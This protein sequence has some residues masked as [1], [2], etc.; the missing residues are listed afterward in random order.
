[1]RLIGYSLGIP[2]QGEPNAESC[3]SLQ[4][5][6]GVVMYAPNRLVWWHLLSQHPVRYRGGGRTRTP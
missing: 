6:T 2:I 3:A 4:S 5:T 1:M